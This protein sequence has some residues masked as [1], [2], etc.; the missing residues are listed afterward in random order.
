MALRD[1]ITD[2]LLHRMGNPKAALER[3]IYRAVYADARLADDHALA[4]FFYFSH[5]IAGLGAIFTADEERLLW[6]SI[7]LN[8]RRLRDITRIVRPKRGELIADVGCGIGGLAFHLSEAGTRVLG[9]I[10]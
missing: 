6:D 5:P 3:L 1:E 7:G 10:R 2:D 8:R 9:L 4:A